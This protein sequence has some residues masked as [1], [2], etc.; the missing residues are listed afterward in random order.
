MFAS[1]R[2]TFEMSDPWF[3]TVENMDV[4]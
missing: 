3:S 2:Y 4:C 1:I